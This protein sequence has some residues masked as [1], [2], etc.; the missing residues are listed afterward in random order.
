MIW[1]LLSQKASQT[2]NS[3]M[4]KCVVCMDKLRLLV[5]GYCILQLDCGL[6][7]IHLIYLFVLEVYKTQL[8]KRNFLSGK[9]TYMHGDDGIL[10]Y[11][12]MPAVYLTSY[13]C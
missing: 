4:S 2:L 6:L 12:E 9:I 13:I 8:A 5:L 7:F 3:I 1:I 10:R 11:H